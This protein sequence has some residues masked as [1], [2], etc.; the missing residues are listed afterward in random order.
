MSCVCAHTGIVIETSV[1]S[2]TRGSCAACGERAL[3]PAHDQY[4]GQADEGQ[5]QI[6]VIVPACLR[7]LLPGSARSTLPGDLEILYQRAV[8]L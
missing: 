7:H 4:T 5:R 8:H 1:L 2:F 6:T 3:I